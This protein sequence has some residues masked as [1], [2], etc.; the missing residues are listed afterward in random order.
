MKKWF[1][2]FGK[3]F[4]CFFKELTMQLPYGS[5]FS[6]LSIY[7]NEIKTSRHTHKKTVNVYSR[8]I[9]NLQKLKPTL[10]RKMGKQILAYG[11]NGI[12]L[13]SKWIRTTD[14]VTIRMN[15]KCFMLNES[16]QI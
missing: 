11:Y 12:H 8:F 7:R 5:T 3:Q 16:S 9:G 6:F 1:N 14:L 10:N 13:S 15:L 4:R 2:D